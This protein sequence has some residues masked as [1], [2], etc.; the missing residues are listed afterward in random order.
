[1]G[2]HALI[3]F[4][5]KVDK[6]K[7]Y[8]VYRHFD[9]S[10][11]CACELALFFAQHRQYLKSRQVAVGKEDAVKVLVDKFLIWA[12]YYLPAMYGHRRGSSYEFN[13]FQSCSTLMNHHAVENDQI[14]VHYVWDVEIDFIQST[15]LTTYFINDMHVEI[16]AYSNQS[17]TADEELTEKVK[18]EM[19]AIELASELSG[20][21]IAQ[22]V[23]YFSVKDA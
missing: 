20:N 21:P 18:Q 8:R 5:D 12:N 2:T 1:M 23:M 17:H 4:Y 15:I 3:K 9:G 22:P 16:T 7:V 19:I 10:G 11:I 6:D 14:H 13:I